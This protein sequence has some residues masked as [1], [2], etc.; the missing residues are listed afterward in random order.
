MDGIEV[1]VSGLSD[2]LGQGQRVIVGVMIT[3]GMSYRPVEILPVNE[4]TSSF[5]YR[6]FRHDIFP[7]SQMS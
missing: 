3:E 5:D 7:Q 1:P 4:D 2:S 6:F